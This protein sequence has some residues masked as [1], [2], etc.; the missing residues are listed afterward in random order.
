MAANLLKNLLLAEDN[1]DV[2]ETIVM[3]LQLFHYNIA[4]VVSKA[5]EAVQKAGELKPDLVIMDVMLEDGT[6]G[7]RAGKQIQE[8][9]GIPVLYITGYREKAAL[10]ECEGSVPLLKPFNAN[11]LK[12]AIGAIFYTLSFKDSFKK[13]FIPDNP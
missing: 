8:T 10:L 1:S 12:I 2:A 6:D 3:A 13:P 7:I 9:M 11:D 4:A 5:E